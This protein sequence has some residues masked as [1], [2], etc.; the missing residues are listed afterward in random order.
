MAAASTDRAM[1]QRSAPL[2][3]TCHCGAIR[4]HVR[5]MS[6]TLTSCNCSIC[7]RYG[8]LWAYYAESSVSIEAPK[9]GLERYS[10]NRKIRAYYRCRKCG[11]VT[12]YSYLKQRRTRTVAVNAVNFD[13]SVLAGARIRHLDG[14]ASW[15]F[16]D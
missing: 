7:R 12:H 8:A 16:L 3:A 4:I 9:G 10:W 11:C 2:T 1:T 14:G 5:R 15:K 13:P 6:R